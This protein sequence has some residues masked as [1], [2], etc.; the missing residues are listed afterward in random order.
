[1]LS[2]TLSFFTQMS[3]PQKVSLFGLFGKIR[4]CL[5]SN[6]VWPVLITN[7]CLSLA[8]LERKGSTA[9]GYSLTEIKH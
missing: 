6:S 9:L 1:M 8:E 2:L 3:R 7:G 4:H 5:N